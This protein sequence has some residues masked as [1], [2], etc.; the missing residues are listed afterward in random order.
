MLKKVFIILDGPM[1]SG[2]TTTAKILH[3]RLP[4][5]VF[6]SWDELKGLI[7]G[8]GQEKG[9]KMILANI[10][11]S[12]VISGVENRLNI[13]LDAGFAQGNRMMYFNRLAKQNKYALLVYQFTAPHQVLLQRALSRPKLFWEK[14]KISPA[15]IIKNLRAY[16]ANKYRGKIKAEINSGHLTSDQIVKIIL[17]DLS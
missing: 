11:K 6:I 14:K 3:Q 10:Q 12:L 13:L 9:D 1:G 2:K 16:R 8:Y 7:S 15:R 4:R 17:K 5:T